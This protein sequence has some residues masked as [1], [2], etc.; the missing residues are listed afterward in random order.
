MR[1]EPIAA[2]PRE[3]K[4][5]TERDSNTKKS[6]FHDIKKKGSETIEFIA[7][8]SPCFTGHI[9]MPQ[10]SRTIFDPGFDRGRL[11]FIPLS[12]ILTISAL[13]CQS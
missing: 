5:E 11:E 7:R 10:G 8:T 2:P 3:L 6:F 4:N 1:R 9:R 13:S 12:T